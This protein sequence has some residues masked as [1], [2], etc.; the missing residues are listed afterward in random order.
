MLNLKI[1]I[2][3]SI[4]KKIIILFLQLVFTGSGFSN[5]PGKYENVVFIIK[6]LETGINVSKVTL[7]S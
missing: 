6:I 2:I 4:L 1:L 5:I 7:R 3:F